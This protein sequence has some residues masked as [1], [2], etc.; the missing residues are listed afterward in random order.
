MF[1]L[2][3]IY[4]QVVTNYYAFTSAEAALPSAQAAVE[5]SER[6]FRGFV[7]QY[8]TGTASILDVLH[9]FDNFKQC[10]RTAGIDTYAMGISAC[11]SGLFSRRA[12]RHS[13]TCKWPQKNLLKTTVI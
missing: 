12:R 8:K 5:Y 1:R 10:A 2:A 7:I 9:R 4:T 13:G 6:A 11:K 3:T